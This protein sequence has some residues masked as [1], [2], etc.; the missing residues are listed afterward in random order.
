MASI[1]LPAPAAARAPRLLPAPRV[2]VRDVAYLAPAMA[3]GIASFTVVVTGLALAAGLLITVV[4][5]AVLVATL[6]AARGLGMLERRRAAWLLEAPI[7]DPERA[8]TG[9]PVAIVKAAVTDRAAWRDALWSLALMPVGIA[10]T[11]V[12]LTLWA[13]AL[14]LV[15]SPA[16]WWALPDDGSSPEALNGHGLGPTMLRLAIGVALVPVS[17]WACRALAAST[18]RLT[19]AAIG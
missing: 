18:A 7:P 11:T 3:I 17:A 4:G 16:W 10:V 12:G 13:T 8:W 5:V 15:S 2:M 19:R 1:P 6:Y 14:G 9:G